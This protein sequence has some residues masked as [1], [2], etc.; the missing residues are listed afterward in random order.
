[1]RWSRDGSEI[2][3]TALDGRLMSVPVHVEPDGRAVAPGPTAPL[4]AAPVPLAF[5]GGTALP[6]YMVSRDG[7]RFLMTEPTPLTAVPITV[8]LN[9][10]P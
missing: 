7:K 3:Y 10:K 6:W 5:G 8:L 1:M 9:W 2:F 4:F